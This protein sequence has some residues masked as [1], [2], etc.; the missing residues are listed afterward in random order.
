MNKEELKKVLELNEPIFVDKFA[1]LL[2]PYAKFIYLAGLVLLAFMVLLSVVTL[3]TGAIS[4]SIITL[5][6]VCI[7]FVLLRMFCEF[8]VSYR[9]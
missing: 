4:A 7:E 5:F 1:G 2:Q 9:K 6:F 3:L 8:L